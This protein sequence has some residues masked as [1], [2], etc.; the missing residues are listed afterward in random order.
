MTRKNVLTALYSS[1]VLGLFLPWFNL[2]T[3]LSDSHAL[4]YI[5]SPLTVWIIISGI[6]LFLPGNSKGQ[7]I[8][9]FAFLSLIP[10]TCL[11][12]F[13][14]WHMLLLTGEANIIHSLA[15]KHYGFFLTFVS[16]LILVM[17][18]CVNMLKMDLEN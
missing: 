14:T 17:V 2:G 15:S 5:F 9:T 10:L 7:V 11:Y 18:Y 3:D 16:S 12:Y 1:T 8:S 6:L 13:L 4:N